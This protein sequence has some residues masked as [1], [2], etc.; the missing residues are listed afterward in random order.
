MRSQWM[1]RVLENRGLLQ[2]QGGHG[3]GGLG[4]PGLRLNGDLLGRLGE[5]QGQHAGSIFRRGRRGG[6]GGSCRA[7]GT[8]GE[9]L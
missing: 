3:C 6:S 1:W 7:E 2:L 5:G 8:R 9:V 4:G